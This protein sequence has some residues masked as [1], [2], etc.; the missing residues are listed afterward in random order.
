MCLAALQEICNCKNIVTRSV[1]INC[2]WVLCCV[3]C[4]SGAVDSGAVDSVLRVEG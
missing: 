1:K 2:Y 4:G 3:V